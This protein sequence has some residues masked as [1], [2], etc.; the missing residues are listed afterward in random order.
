MCVVRLLN[1]IIVINGELVDVAISFLSFAL[2]LSFYLHIIRYSPALFNCLV[3]F[4]YITYWTCLHFFLLSCTYS[5][6]LC[7]CD[8]FGQQHVSNWI[9]V[10]RSI[11]MNMSIQNKGP[12]N[13]GRWFSFFTSSELPFHFLA[14]IQLIFRLFWLI[15]VQSN[16]SQL[17]IVYG[18]TWNKL[19]KDFGKRL[20]TLNGTDN[21]NVLS[22]VSNKIAQGQS[23]V[24]LSFA[25]VIVWKKANILVCFCL[26]KKIAP[27]DSEQAQKITQIPFA[28]FECAQFTWICKPNL[29]KNKQYPTIFFF[30]WISYELSL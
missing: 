28:F 25:D 1:H 24:I 2:F 7:Y 30:L 18:W 20:K 29:V 23:S 19:I 3:R 4:P 22:L 14:E 17:G 26:L 27:G 13:T 6:C 5:R 15:Y 8:S 12:M 10:N 9:F 16:N 21:K 11:Y